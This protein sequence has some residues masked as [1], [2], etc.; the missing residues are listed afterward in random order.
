MECTRAP[1]I[2]LAAGGCNPAPLEGTNNVESAKPAQ[3]PPGPATTPPPPRLWA[4]PPGNCPSFHSSHPRLRLGF[5][6]GARRARA[7]TP[8]FAPRAAGASRAGAPRRGRGPWAKAGPGKGRLLAFAP[9]LP[10]LSRTWGQGGR[11]AA[12]GDR[13]APPVP[14]EKVDENPTMAAQ[15]AKHLATLKEK[16]NFSLVLFSCHIRK[17]N[18][19][20]KSADRAILITD[21]HLYKMDPKKQYK[22]MRATP[23]RLVTGVSVTSGEDQLVVFHMQNSSSLVAC[24]HKMHPT[25]DN[26]VGELVGVLVDHFRRTEMPL[27][28]QVSDCI[29]LSLNGR[30]RLVSVEVHGQQAVPDFA[31]S[32]DGFV[33]WWPRR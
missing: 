15:F 21:Q 9:G 27:R 29:Q 13:G 28:V 11:A 17:V 20:N 8:Q 26:R 32:R 23:L 10:P 14:R 12:G 7:H 33:L 18:R 24:L 5:E 6:R 31:R 19:C 1:I 30:K 22:V 4:A 16:V 25:N 3:G 2:A